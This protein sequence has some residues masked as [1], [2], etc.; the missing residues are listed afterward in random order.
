MGWSI[1]AMAGLAGAGVLFSA[2]ANAQESGAAPSFAD[3]EMSD[4][5]PMIGSVPG[6][7][8]RVPGGALQ[9]YGLLNP[10]ISYISAS[11]ARKG[12]NEPASA[13]FASNGSYWGLRGGED[14]GAGWQVMFQLENTIN[15]GTGTNTNSSG[16]FAGRSTF[17]GVQSDALGVL[18]FGYLTS[19]LYNTVGIYKFIG[20]QLPIAS[21]T[22]LMTTING[23][24]LQFNNRV[25][26]AVAY[27]TSKD[28]SGLVGH[29]LYSNSQSGDVNQ[30]NRDNVYSLSASYGDGPIYLQYVYEARSNQGRLASGE[31]NDWS[32]RVVGRYAFSDT[33]KL[34]FGLDYSGSD[35]TYGKKAAAGRG[36]VARQAATV[37]LAKAVGRHEFIGTYAFA[38]GIQCSGAAMTA[39][40]NCAPGVSGSTGAQQLSFVYEYIFSKRTLVS[41]FV[42]RIWNRSNGLYDFDA[43]PVVQSASARS[44]GVNP[45]GYGFAIMHI[46]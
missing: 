2:M 36:R 31:S 24:S 6:D 35:G 10:G 11:G 16:Q 39:Q 12:P 22:T 13:V 41:A 28:S 37:S 20:D 15:V 46:F 40:A 30:G 32:N 43:V 19:P 3:A 23:T 7:G 33:L 44:A 14:L 34:A 21:P 8:F 29:F 25:A 27:S 42:S 4:F 1:W 17:I 38:R 26:N 18:K 5:N 9:I 45:T